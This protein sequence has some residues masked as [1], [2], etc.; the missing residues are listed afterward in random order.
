MCQNSAALIARARTV[1]DTL[2]TKWPSTKREKIVFTLRVRLM[3][4]LILTIDSGVVSVNIL[5]KNCS[6]CFVEMSLKV[7]NLSFG[8]RSNSSWVFLPF[9]SGK[10]RYD[11][12]QSGYGGQ[13]KPIF[14][15]KVRKM[16]HFMSVRSYVQLL[17]HC[18]LYLCALG[19][20]FDPMVHYALLLWLDLSGN[21]YSFKLF[22][23][24]T[25]NFWWNVT[26]SID[27][28]FVLIWNM[29]GTKIFVLIS[30]KLLF[31]CTSVYQWNKYFI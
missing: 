12:K 22:S 4:E 25:L 21:G 2:C 1:E 9:L 11:R 18:P 15:K 19:R 8:K 28:S 10:R 23:W 13:T 20:N 27:G 29:Y 30:R 26:V 24:N 3:D 14:H 5:I 17:P 31:L 7:I 6:S 16:K